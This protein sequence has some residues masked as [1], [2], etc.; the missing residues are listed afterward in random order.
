MKTGILIGLAVV[1]VSVATAALLPGSLGVLFLTHDMA[2]KP[3]GT[4]CI[5]E[6]ALPVY[7]LSL[8]LMLTAIVWARCPR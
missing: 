3:W 8:T 5:H 7:L 1:A 2:A 4:F 6:F